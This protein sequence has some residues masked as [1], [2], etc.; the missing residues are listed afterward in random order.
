MAEQ[1]SAALIARR[2]SVLATDTLPNDTIK[3]LL[4]VLEAS[5]IPLTEFPVGLPGFSTIT[6][7]AYPG[8]G[9]T[10]GVWISYQARTR[11]NDRADGT[12]GFAY[13]WG[14]PRRVRMNLGVSILDLSRR[15]QG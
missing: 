15:G 7:G 13:G 12:M 14:N 10:V 2:V 11:Y 1:H 5:H 3:R 6:P 4:A 9:R 8:S